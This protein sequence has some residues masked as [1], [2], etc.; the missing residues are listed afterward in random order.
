LPQLS[1]SRAKNP[2]EVVRPILLSVGYDRALLNIR[3]R[4]LRGAGFDVISAPSVE[5]A[6]HAVE[7]KVP[8]VVILGHRIPPMHRNQITEALKR[9]NSSVRIL[10]LY[11]RAISGAELADAI[12]NV[13]GDPHDLVQTVEYLL[14]KPARSTQV[15]PGQRKKRDAASHS[16]R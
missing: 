1:R 12:L 14:S 3:N 4:L 5:D 8:Q 6:L 13:A 10:M 11:D 16:S 7:N 15:G 2:R 9:V